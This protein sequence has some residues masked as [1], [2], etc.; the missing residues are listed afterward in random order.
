MPY[1]VMAPLPCPPFDP[2][3]PVYAITDNIFLVDATGG[4]LAV[5]P[6]Q[7]AA[8]STTATVNDAAV[9][10]LINQVQTAQANQQARATMRAMGMDVLFV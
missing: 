2:T 3:L 5:N 6:R 4:Q 10:N 1:G 7:A 8:M 9:V